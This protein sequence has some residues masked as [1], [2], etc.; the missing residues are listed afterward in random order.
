MACYSGTV[1]EM[2]TLE[3]LVDGTQEWL[4]HGLY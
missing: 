1:I 2:V 3:A 4:R